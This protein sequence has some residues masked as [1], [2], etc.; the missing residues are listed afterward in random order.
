VIPE[1]R[2][3]IVEHLIKGF[4]DSRT[5]IYSLVVLLVLG[6]AGELLADFVVPHIQYNKTASMPLGFYWEQ[7]IGASIKHDDLVFFCPSTQVISRGLA[8]GV[9]FLRGNCP[10]HTSQFLKR[11]IAVPGDLVDTRENELRINGIPVLASA[12][13]GGPEGAKLRSILPKI[14]QV[15]SDQAWG[16]SEDPRGYDSRYYGSFRPIGIAYPLITW[17]AHAL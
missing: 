15:A 10:G 13:I 11:I 1:K 17:K 16:I 12:P 9:H 7:P 6:L 8:A 4:C 2:P 3:T 5:W 14:Y